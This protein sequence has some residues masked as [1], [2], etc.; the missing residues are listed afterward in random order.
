M[1]IQLN[2]MKSN[3]KKKLILIVEDQDDMNKEYCTLLEAEGFKCI[4]CFNGK[5]GVDAA[6]KYQ[7][8]AISADMMMP[9]MDGIEMIKQIRTDSL[10][11]HTPI[12]A[13]TNMCS[14]KLEREL[15]RIGTN[16]YMI[17][18]EYT[19]QEYVDAIK[20]LLEIRSYIKLIWK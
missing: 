8:D 15:E 11:I 7:F 12:L 18:T 4:P 3:I 17:K 19:M 1:M 20:E 14:N 10:N 13:Y 6:R 16:R 2:Q 5:E 9:V